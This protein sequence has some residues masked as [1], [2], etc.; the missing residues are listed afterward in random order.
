MID[1]DTA[2]HRSPS[3]IGEFARTL[4]TTDV[5]IRWTD[6]HSIRNN[7]SKIV[8]GNSTDATDSVPRRN[9]WV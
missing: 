9:F 5:A 2:E 8:W 4:T 6:S 1:A 7:T 3:L